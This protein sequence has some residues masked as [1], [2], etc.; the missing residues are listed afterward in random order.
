MITNLCRASYWMLLLVALKVRTFSSIASRMGRT[1]AS[2]HDASCDSVLNALA[3]FYIH[4][5]LNSLIFLKL[6]LRL[7]PISVLHMSILVQLHQ[8][9]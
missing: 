8:Y 6:F 3:I 1:P 5:S 9:G 7:S 2:T 4:H